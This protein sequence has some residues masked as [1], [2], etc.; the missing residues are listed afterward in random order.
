MMMFVIL[1]VRYAMVSLFVLMK[2]IGYFVWQI[3]IRIG[4]ENYTNK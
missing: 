1:V 4:K 3:G 2:H